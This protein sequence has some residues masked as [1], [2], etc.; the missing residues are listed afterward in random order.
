MFDNGDD[1]L[2][3]GG[4]GELMQCEGTLPPLQGCYSAAAI[5]DV[6]ESTNT[7]TRQWSYQ[8]P[9]SYWGGVTRVLPNNNMFIT[10]STPADLQ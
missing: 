7:A 2:Q 6:D 10:E 1:R 9:Y 3:P 4:G 8:T 5:F